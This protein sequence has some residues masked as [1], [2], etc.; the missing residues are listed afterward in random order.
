MQM[1]KSKGDC[2]GR[3]LDVDGKMGIKMECAVVLT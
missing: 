2:I 1:L 3:F